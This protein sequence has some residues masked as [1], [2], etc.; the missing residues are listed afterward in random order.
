MVNRAERLELV[1]QEV[2]DLDRNGARV[3]QVVLR[4]PDTW[5]SVPIAEVRSKHKSKAFKEAAKTLIAHAA[6]AR[7]RSGMRF[8]HDNDIQEEV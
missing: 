3:L 1:L 5:E 6:D 7:K 2:Y 8:Y 4:N